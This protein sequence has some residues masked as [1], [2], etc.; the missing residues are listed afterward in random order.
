VDRLF[1]D[2][3]VLFSAAYREQAGLLRLWELKEVQLVTSRYAVAEATRNLVAAEQGSRLESLLATVEVVDEVDERTMTIEARLPEKDR[4][5]LRAAVSAR[6]THLITGD[7]THFGPFYG[8]R[9]QG[10]LVVAPGEYLRSRSRTD[11]KLD[12]GG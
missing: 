3:N 1:L 12:S 9:L 10:V 7:V 5:I 6:A 8:Q 11:S 2:A 4:P